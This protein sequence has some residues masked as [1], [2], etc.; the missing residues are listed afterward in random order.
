M[1]PHTVMRAG[2]KSQHARGTPMDVEAVGVRK[3]RS[4]AVAR[5]PE[6]EHGLSLAEPHT[7][8][9]SVLSHCAA[10]ELTGSVQAESLE[11]RVLG[12]RG[13][14]GDLPALFGVFPES[15]DTRRQDFLERLGAAD[16][17]LP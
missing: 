6:K 3:L 8:E 10:H 13:I 7:A 5:G 11:E 15:V 9:R 12:E 16:E 1:A 17:E 4:I 2:A 14:A